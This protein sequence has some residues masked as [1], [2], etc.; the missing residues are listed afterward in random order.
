LNVG[1]VLVLNNAPATSSCVTTAPTPPTMSR[2]AISLGAK[3]SAIHTA[4]A[5]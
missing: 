4:A 2:A 1:R 5:L 3:E